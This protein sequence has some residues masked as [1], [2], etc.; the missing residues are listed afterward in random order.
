MEILYP[1]AGFL[2]RQDDRYQTQPYRY[3]FMP[4]I[5]PAMPLDTRLAHLPFPPLNS[6]VRFDHQ[7][8]KTSTFFVGDSSSL[9]ECCFVPRHAR[10][11]EGDGYLIGVA[12]RL[13][14]GGRA[15]LVILD[16]QHLEQGVIAT[17]KLP[18]SGNPQ[19]HGHWVA[20]QSLGE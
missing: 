4:V 9:Q 10:A 8:R 13:L 1:Q 16:A 7:T 14:E 19:I 20:E 3:G 17:V 2:P 18:F 11:A 12:N 5:D 15:D 6:Y